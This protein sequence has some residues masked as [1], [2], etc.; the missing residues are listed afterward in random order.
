MV[1]AESQVQ[2]LPLALTLRLKT[3]GATPMILRV[4]KGRHMLTTKV[5]ASQKG[6]IIRHQP[7]VLDFLVVQD[8]LDS[9]L[10]PMA[11]NINMIQT[12]MLSG[13]L[14]LVPLQLLVQSHY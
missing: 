14:D 6:T 3:P 7:E 1:V 2:L 9:I 4:T 5:R 11:V 10:L 12:V 13:S 8:K